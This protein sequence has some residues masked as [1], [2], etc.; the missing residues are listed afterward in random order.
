MATTILVVDDNRGVRDALQMVLEDEGFRVVT[1]ANGR[2][3]LERVAAE[4]PD[5]ILLDLQMPVMSGWEMHRRLRVLGLRIPVVFM[6][7]AGNAAAE[8]AAHGA[9]GSLTKPFEIADLVRTARR[10]DAADRPSSHGDSRPPIA[11][12]TGPRADTDTRAH[13]ATTGAVPHRQSGDGL[14][15]A[16][17]HTKEHGRCQ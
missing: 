5:L 4:A 17:R 13:A 16:P 11:A 3:G 10:F 9:D 15:P 14:P 2:Q 1:A 7:S 6:T 8:A 12:G